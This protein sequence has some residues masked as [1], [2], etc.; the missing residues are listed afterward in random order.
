MRFA[1]TVL[2]L[3][4]VAVVGFPLWPVEPNAVH[5]DLMLAGPQAGAWLGYDEV[6]R[7]VWDRLLA[8]AVVSLQVALVAVTGSMLIGIP[9]GL[10]SG[11]RGG[12]L[13]H[14]VVRIIDVVLAFP[15]LLLAIALAGMLGPGVGNVVIAL[16]AVGWV[17]FARLTR[18]Q[19][20]S[21]RER[22]HV[23]A[24]RVLGTG[25]GRILLR[26]LLPLCAA[27]LIVE[28]T[29]GIAVAVLSEAGLS[30]LGLGVQPPTASW[31]SMIRDGSRYLLVAPHYVLAPGIALCLVVLAVNLAGDAL[32]DRLDVTLR[33]G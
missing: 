19:V 15:G 11:Y 3:W 28:A 20:L 30:Y 27:P 7:A 4:V 2:G 32:R 8:G 6:G 14:L 26:H 17:G 25:T 23:L 13:D 21:L 1:V 31:G 29:F 16:V 33:G 18:A 12:A 5:L 10:L 9:V 22:D 24:A